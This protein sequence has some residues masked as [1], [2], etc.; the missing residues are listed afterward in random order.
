MEHLHRLWHM[1]YSS[2]LTVNDILLALLRY[3]GQEN[4]GARARNLF[5]S[6]RYVSVASLCRSLIEDLQN[7]QLLA[8]FRF[9]SHGFWNNSL[10][11]HEYSSW[12][13]CSYFVILSWCSHHSVLFGPTLSYSFPS[14]GRHFVFY[15]CSSYNIFNIGCFFGCY[16]FCIGLVGRQLLTKFCVNT[17]ATNI[18]LLN[19]QGPGTL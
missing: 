7:L 1:P 15:Y 13:G 9:R 3:R 11:V 19:G 8:S 2:Y 12:Q 14:R 5:S 6:E 4:R 17:I 16:G 10:Q 18:E